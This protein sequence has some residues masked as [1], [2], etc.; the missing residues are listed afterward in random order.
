MK[1][2]SI[3]NTYRCKTLDVQPLNEQIYR[4]RLQLDDGSRL[5]FKGG[6]YIIL[7]MP[8]DVRVPLSIASAPEKNDFIEL[9]IRLIKGH[10]LA[11][12]MIDLFSNTASFYIEGPC[13]DCVLNT[14]NRDLIIIAGGTGFSPMKSLIE[15]AFCQQSKRQIQLFLGAQKFT[16][17][18]QHE[19]I[20][21]WEKQNN[22]FSYIPVISGD[23]KIWQGERGFPH[24]VAINENKQ[25]LETK[26]FYVSG[27]EPMVMAV[28]KELLASSVDKFHIHSDIL[29][30]K[31]QNGEIK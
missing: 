26:D 6:Q 21:Q 13:G 14:S 29:S 16:D 2:T 22:N 7:H 18:Y 28:Y 27:S 5:Q 1:P 3:V 15:S 24:Q 4:V 25:T 9:H 8:N 30:I 10:S 17:L 11:Q 31:R 20:K 19:L 12:E 23:D